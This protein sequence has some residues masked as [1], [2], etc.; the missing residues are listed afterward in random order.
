M[1]KQKQIL[2]KAAKLHD[3]SGF[4]YLIRRLQKQ[5]LC[6]A[7]FSEAD[8]EELEGADFEEDNEELEEKVVESKVGMC[9][10]NPDEEY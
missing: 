6:D 3:V 1:Q 2:N 4:I 7:S 8:L 10:N 5:P 9:V